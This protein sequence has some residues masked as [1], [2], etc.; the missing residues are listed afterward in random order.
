MKRT[1]NADNMPMLPFADIAIE[2]RTI[3]ALSAVVNSSNGHALSEQTDV[4]EK[5]RKAKL[6][7]TERIIERKA[8]KRLKVTFAD[9]T[10]INEKS[11]TQ[12]MIATIERLGIQ[13]VVELKME[14]CHVPLIS[15]EIVPKYKEWTKPMSGG[16]Y[17]L[18][19]SDTT[20][21]HLQLLLSIRN[22]LG[23]NFKV[24]TV[25]AISCRHDV[26]TKNSSSSKTKR[27]LVV[28]LDNGT[29]LSGVRHADIFIEI[30]KYI[31]IDKVASSNVKVCQKPIIT[32]TKQFNN[33]VELSQ[34]RWLTIPTSVKDK[35]RAI[36]ILASVARLKF[37][38]SL[39]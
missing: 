1:K 33:Q 19:Q 38:V 12:T 26:N 2:D 24:E 10:I 35:Y 29:V 28:K 15:K 22:K 4:A 27:T 3:D 39:Q 11:A 9:G 17:L 21:K 30:I 6:S 5:E 36:M 8:R 20:Q 32:S 25:D 13:R 14:C 31:G 37:E 18:S 16:W 23:E 34:A 7:S